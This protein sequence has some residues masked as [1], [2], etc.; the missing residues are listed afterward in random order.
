MKKQITILFA[1]LALFVAI[2]F[3]HGQEEDDGAT[4]VY[5]SEI[6]KDN[7]LNNEAMMADF[8]SKYG[9]Y[10]ED[11]FLFAVYLALAAIPFVIVY[12]AVG[13]IR[14]AKK[15]VM[16]VVEEISELQR[17]RD[18]RKHEKELEKFYKLKEKAQIEMKKLEVD[19]MLKFVQKP[20]DISKELKKEFKK[21][22]AGRRDRV[23]LEIMAGRMISQL[24]GQF[25]MTDVMKTLDNVYGS[26]IKSE[27]K[28]DM[29]AEIKEWTEGGDF[30]SKYRV[31]DGVQY[32]KMIYV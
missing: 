1:V 31:I 12:F 27:E 20:D 13:A 6:K 14:G 5:W 24:N 28:V 29:I 25:C 32:Y 21:W 7:K 18:I 2:I 8:S 19:K 30:C 11:A 26:G 10:K 3:V 9:Q 4:I 23:K 16:P 17:M 15:V 22:P